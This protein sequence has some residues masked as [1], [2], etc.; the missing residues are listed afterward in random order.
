[1]AKS[2]KKSKADV[3]ARV[4]EIRKNFF[5]RQEEERRRKEAIEAARPKGRISNIQLPE[6][7]KKE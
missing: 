7:T 2:T 3:K 6:H 5:E 4:D 1:M